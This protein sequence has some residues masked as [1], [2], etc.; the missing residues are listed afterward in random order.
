MT[1]PINSWGQQNMEKPEKV[2]SISK[3]D[4]RSGTFVSMHFGADSVRYRVYMESSCFYGRQGN[5]DDLD[6]NKLCGIS[7]GRHQQN[8]LRIGWRPNFDQEGL[9]ELFSYVY[10]DGKRNFTK[11]ADVP[12]EEVF[13][14]FFRQASES[15]WKIELITSTF[16]EVHT[17]EIESGGKWGYN[18]FP[19]FGGNNTAPQEIRILM[20]R[21]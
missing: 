12:V 4:H 13:E 17:I 1:I 20:D 16:T 14:V 18:L 11:M 3:G 5:I 6:L 21:L 9:I 2:Y 15:E 10:V 19:Y 8:S 7:F